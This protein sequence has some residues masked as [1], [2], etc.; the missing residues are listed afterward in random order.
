[1]VPFRNILKTC[2]KKTESQV[3][4]SRQIISKAYRIECELGEIAASSHKAVVGRQTIYDSSRE[5]FEATSSRER[6]KSNRFRELML[7]FSTD[8]S[9]RKAAERLNR[10]RQEQQGITPTTY[11]N[12]IEREGQGMQQCMERKCNEALSRN[13]FGIHNELPYNSTFE[14]DGGRYIQQDEV[15]SAA[16]ELNIKKFRLSDYESPEHSVNI[17]VDDV[18]V[19]RQ[20]DKRPKEEDST[21]P[22]RVNNT[23]IHVQGSEGKYIL[24][25]ATLFGAL[26]LL[27]GFLL[28]CGL[29][30]YQLVFFTDGARDLHNAIPKVFPFANIKIVLDWYHLKKKCQE[31]LSM[32]LRGSKIRNEFLE[33]LLPCLWFGNV[34]GAILLLQTIDG[35]KIKNPAIIT[36]LIEYLERVRGFVPCYALRKKL[37]LRNSSNLGEKA[38][39]LVVANRQKH[40]GMSWSG[41]GSVAF[42]SVASASCNNEINN[43]VHF[44]TIELALVD[45][46]AA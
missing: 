1:M 29:L 34:D 26:R 20:S 33:E 5:F 9:D 19:K 31:Q 42:A 2:L 7:D 37:G 38:N 36:K 35:N 3:N 41:E 18:C 43:W 45:G 8:M 11:R 24:N 17:S 14:P 21:Q 40:N 39:D 25:A 30:G 46:T 23:V 32:A 28:H 4:E 10:I 6:F 15:E 13:G 16:K 44:R 22:K 12:T 27:A